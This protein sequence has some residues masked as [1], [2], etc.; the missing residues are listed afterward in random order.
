MAHDEATVRA[1]ED[2]CYLETANGTTPADTTVTLQIEA[3]GETIDPYAIDGPDVL[4]VGRRCKELG[5]GFYWAPFEEAPTLVTPKGKHIKTINIDNVPYIADGFNI[6]KHARS[7][8]MPVVYDKS[9]AWGSATAAR[10]D[11]S[12]RRRRDA[13]TRTS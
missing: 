4:S 13:S 2:P 11:S 3:T 5:Y 10:R 6:T 1:S 8:A 9:N 7:R 12:S